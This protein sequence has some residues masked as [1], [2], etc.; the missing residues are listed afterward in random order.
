VF[1]Y[2]AVGGIFVK[3]SEIID[4]KDSNLT[5]SCNLSLCD[6]CDDIASANAAASDTSEGKKSVA[7]KRDD[8][9]MRILSNY[10]LYLGL[11]LFVTGLIFSFSPALESVLFLTSYALAGAEVIFLMLKNI[12]K[13]DVFDENFLM[14]IA[15][16]GAIAIGEY[17]E[18][19]AV[20]IFYRAG[21]YFQE[22]AVNHARKAIT[23]LM[24]IRP[25]YAN[26]KLGSDVLKVSP[27][28]VRVGDHIIVRP[29]ERVPLDGTV[30][31]GQSALDVSMLTGEAL[32]Y[33]VEVGKVVL[34]GS[35]NKQG[36]LTIEVSKPYGEST[37]SKILNLVQNAVSKKSHTE[38]FITRFARYYTPIVVFAAIALA[39]LPPLL[40]P[41]ASF[42]LWF[43]RALIFL[44]VSCPCALVISIPLS[45]FGGIGGA[46][47]NGI[48]VKGA[49]Y[50]EALNKVDTVVFDKTGTLTKGI[51]SVTHI[52]PAN[53]F[54]KDELLY[55]AAYAESASGHPI[56]V[57]I[58][59][60]YKGKIDVA[61][62]TAYKE[63][64][65][66]GV[67][68]EID[69]MDV[70][71]GN[72]RMC[73]SR[74]IECH[75]SNISGTGVHVA[76]GGVYAGYLL[77]ADELKPDSRKAISL[78][79]KLGVRH[80][81]MLTGDKK[82]ISQKTAEELGL[83][84]MH[85]E[86][87]PHQKVE[88]LES[89]M[90]K[91]GKSKG[92]IVFAGDGINDAPVLARSDIGIAMGGIG[93]DA[94]IEAADVVLMTD[95]P[96]KVAVSIMIA[97]KTHRIVWQNIIFALGTEVVVLTLSAFGLAT[98]WMAVFSDGGVAIIAVL[99]AMRAMK[100]ERV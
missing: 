95:E 26:L 29:G 53:G 9:F 1:A 84:E 45:F 28:E 100:V 4:G 50:L 22:K 62:V 89:Y 17:P 6:V 10:S 67:V 3:T 88:L 66:Q 36:L 73:Q 93:S 39:V 61:R 60:A 49:N 91:S 64:A 80:I 38:N 13:G 99:N 44:V 70:I 23:S 72:S 76:I 74:G 77:V 65:G 15:T 11:L 71:A 31:E 57:S 58:Q 54:G 87:L 47:R 7:T 52:E 69:G 96:S 97:R 85:C 32:P 75:D 24:D 5:C 19:A 8:D 25:D 21:L 40:L 14:G 82:D 90:E 48:L 41:D 68:A 2:S 98:M 37:V 20:M 63:I 30:I 51:F 18:A 94:A 59:K 43:H 79:R 78:L 42:E 83:N 35:I 12:L 55:Y 81:A 34:S 56:A 86:L 33:D 92:K 16:I 46:S 27:L